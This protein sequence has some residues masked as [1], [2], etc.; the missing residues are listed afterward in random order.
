MMSTKTTPTTLDDTISVNALK[1]VN[2]SLFKQKKRTPSSPVDHGD[3]G[4]EEEEV[5]AIDD[6]FEGGPLLQEEEEDVTTAI[7]TTT[8]TIPIPTTTTVAPLVV[9]THNPYQRPL[10]SPSFRA[11]SPEP[12]QQQK[13]QPSPPLPRQ[14][15]YH[16]DP[17]CCPPPYGNNNMPHGPDEYQERMNRMIWPILLRDVPDR[18]IQDEYGNSPTRLPPPAW[19]HAPVLGGNALGG[20]NIRWVNYSVHRRAADVVY[21]QC[22]TYNDKRM[23]LNMVP[24]WVHRTDG[25]V[26]GTVARRDD[27]ARLRVELMVEAML[28][29]VRYCGYGVPEGVHVRRVTVVPGDASLTRYH[30]TLCSVVPGGAEGAIHSLHRNCFAD[31]AGFWVAVN[32]EG[33]ELMR[34]YSVA[35]YQLPQAVRHFIMGNVPYQSIVAEIS[36][37]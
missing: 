10:E 5:R 27:D 11:F 7:T 9:T 22:S 12:Q 4:V 21:S 33:R 3:E 1:Y 2:D 25:T 32:E 17:V 19:V 20:N 30:V 35:A 31:R 37:K 14:Q 29:A 28:E 23:F 24:R 6:N 15:Q 8:T 16:P 26:D 36:R 18:L 34:N 13:Q